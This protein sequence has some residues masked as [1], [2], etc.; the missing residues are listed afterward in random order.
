MRFSYEILIWDSHMS[1]PNY[2]KIITK[3]NK[4]IFFSIRIFNSQT[5]FACNTIVFLPL[6]QIHLEKQFRLSILGV[7]IRKKISKS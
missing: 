1:S 3:T 6:L 7:S 2:L 5:K 4:F